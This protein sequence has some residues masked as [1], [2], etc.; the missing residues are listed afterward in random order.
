MYLFVFTW[1]ETKLCTMLL[2]VSHK[3]TDCG[4][5]YWANARS[6][7]RIVKICIFL[8]YITIRIVL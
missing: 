8:R 3:N 5:L 1:G 2:Q 7:K 6:L 4:A